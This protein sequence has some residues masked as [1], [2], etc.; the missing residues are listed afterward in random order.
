MK[1]SMVMTVIGKDRPGLVESLS[2]IIE[3]HDGNWEESRMVQLAG[4]FAGLL[5][6]HVPAPRAAD[7]EAALG[8]LDRISVVVQRVPAEPSADD[9]THFLQL[10][11]VGQDHPGIVR[12]LA[13]AIA[14]REVNVEELETELESAPM[15]GEQLFRAR[16]RLRAPRSV[17]LDELAQDLEQLAADLMV[18]LRLDEPGT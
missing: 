2:A 9:T 14:A 6:V 10:E 15:S 12:R 4:E 3:E 7:L 11:V 18:E 13:A 8:G 16:A 5:H 1:E 17:G